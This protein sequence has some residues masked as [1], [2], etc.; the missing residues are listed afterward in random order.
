MPSVPPPPTWSSRASASSK[1]VY[2][3]KPPISKVPGDWAAQGA[4][5]PRA[6]TRRKEARMLIAAPQCGGS[7]R[8]VPGVGGGTILNLRLGEANPELA[9]PHQ[10]SPGAGSAS[11]VARRAHKHHRQD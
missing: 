10:A 8:T 7:E 5:I 1:N 6:T 9:Q 11:S 4:A 2:R 3:A